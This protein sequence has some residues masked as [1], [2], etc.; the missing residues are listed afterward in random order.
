MF[1]NKRLAEKTVKIRRLERK[2]PQFKTKT[3]LIKLKIAKLRKETKD[4]IASLDSKLHQ[5]SHTPAPYRK[6]AGRASQ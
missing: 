4:K 6:S 3:N 1:G 2:A 5:K